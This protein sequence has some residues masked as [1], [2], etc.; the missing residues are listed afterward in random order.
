MVADIISP[1]KVILN[2]GSKDSIAL[3]QIFLIYALGKA[4]KDPV[5]GE[6]LERLEIVRG[7]GRVVHLQEKICTIESTERKMMPKTVKKTNPGSIGYLLGGYT[8]ETSVEP[9]DQPFNEAQIGD[10]AKKL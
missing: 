8:E 6:E 7:K 4:I 2:K 9:E 1:F 3:G 5:T 10:R